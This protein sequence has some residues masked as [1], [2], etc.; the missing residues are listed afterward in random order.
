[1]RKYE[2]QTLREV[3]H[4]QWVNKTNPAD[5]FEFTFAVTL[6]FDN[7]RLTLSADEDNMAILPGDADFERKRY[8]LLHAFNGRI[9]LRDDAM[10]GSA[11]WAPAINETLHSIEL[12][13]EDDLY[14]SDS[15]LLNFGKE[16][17][18]ISLGLEGLTVEPYEEV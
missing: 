5:I 14:R 1:M 10:N 11:L 6:V 12:V 7:G 4:T 16:Q 18:V 13:K 2:N 15:M 17:I 3:H 8:E 9:D